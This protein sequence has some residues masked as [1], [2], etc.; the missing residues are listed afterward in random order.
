MWF[1]IL[2]QQV[3]LQ[4]LAKP[5]AKITLLQ[6]VNEQGMHIAIHA[7]PHQ[8]EANKELINYLSKLFRIPKSKITLKR[9]EGS[10]HKVV[11]LPLT[12]NLQCFLDNP[13]EFML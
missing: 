7:K 5:N 12:A 11:I 2:G 8:G 1:K 9:G 13:S 10:R 3:E 4:I 6:L